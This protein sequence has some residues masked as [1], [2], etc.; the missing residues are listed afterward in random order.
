[1]WDLDPIKAPTPFRSSLV[2]R[3][4]DME[5]MRCGNFIDTHPPGLVSFATATP[6]VMRS[7]AYDNRC[8][9]CVFL[10]LAKYKSASERADMALCSSWRLGIWPG[11][12]SRI[13]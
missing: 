7:R 13:H 6:A 9:D 5:L 11:V 3:L 1:M 4:R 8:H 10:I 2:P 12:F